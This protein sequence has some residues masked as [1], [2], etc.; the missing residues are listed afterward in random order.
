MGKTR[1]KMIEDLQLRNY[2]SSTCRNYVDCARAFVA[3]HGRP[4]EQMGER[5]VRQFLLHLALERKA[6]SATQKMHVAGIKF[7]VSFRQACV[8]ARAAPGYRQSR[9]DGSRDYGTTRAAG[10]AC[11]HG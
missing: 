7:L 3:Y 4:A 11:G 2:A 9:R 10:P 5:E 8:T 6:G 1:D